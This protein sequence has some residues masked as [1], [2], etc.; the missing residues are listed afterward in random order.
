[1]I[2]NHNQIKPVPFEGEHA[3]A[4]LIRAN[5]KVQFFN[6]FLKSHFIEQKQGPLSFDARHSNFKNSIHP[7]RER[8]VFSTFSDQT[9]KPHCAIHQTE[10][11]PT[12]TQR[13][14][15]REK[16]CEKEP[17][18]NDQI[19]RRS[20][21][22]FFLWS[23]GECGLQSTRSFVSFKRERE[24][25]DREEVIGGRKRLRINQFVRLCLLPLGSGL[26]SWCCKYANK[27][28]RR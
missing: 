6:F 19:Q 25:T 11:T 18:K 1:M 12:H 4:S 21:F 10:E 14:R 17:Q 26:T 22:A 15:E 5:T 16:G 7:Q 27:Q 3:P 20:Q 28:I 23:V 24:G 9:N 2:L 8:Y 13:E